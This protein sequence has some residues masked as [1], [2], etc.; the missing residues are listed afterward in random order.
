MDNTFAFD[1]RKES[2]IHQLQMLGVEEG[3]K[4]LTTMQEFSK[5]HT[6]EVEKFHRHWFESYTF[7]VK[8]MKGAFSRL[9]KISVDNLTVPKGE[10]FV[11][12]K[13]NH[14]FWADMVYLSMPW[15]AKYNEI[16]D[17]SKFNRL[18]IANKWYFSSG[19]IG[20]ILIL[21]NQL[22]EKDL[23]G[24]TGLKLGIGL[25]KGKIGNN[26]LFKML[27]LPKS[28]TVEKEQYIQMNTDCRFINYYNS[29]IGINLWDISTRMLGKQINYFDSSW[30][31]KL[32]EKYINSGVCPWWLQRQRT[33]ILVMSKEYAIKVAELFRL[34]GY[35][36]LVVPDS[37]LNIEWAAYTKSIIKYTTNVVEKADKPVTVITRCGMV[38]VILGLQL[39]FMAKKKG[40]KDFCYLDYGNLLSDHIDDVR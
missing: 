13:I 30:L 9:P 16:Y 20:S 5:E 7:Q 36:C 32:S 2:N 38:S 24:D 15:L 28:N 33:V 39:Y 23:Q 19:L 31:Y 35:C 21:Q 11:Y 25:G 29:C 26:D 4:I 8:L 6:A 17:T 10:L 3:Q 1:S 34:E 40:W 22:S 27:T 18:S 12:I 14:G 37:G